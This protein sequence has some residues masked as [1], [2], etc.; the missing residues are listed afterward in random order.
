MIA[1]RVMQVSAHQV[2][3]VI[4]MRH[5]FVPAGWTMLV[6]A[7]RL[8]RALHGIGRID[9]DGVL[10]DMILVHVVQMPVVQII[11]V[12]L[13]AY[14]RMPAVGTMLVGMVGMMLLGAGGH[15][16][17]FL[18]LCGRSG[19]GGYRLSAACSMALSTKRTTWVSESE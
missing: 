16:V 1:M 9:R 7:T 13:M 18:L 10:V 4:S 3:D 2:I 8:R 19:T 11:D 5:G 12:A 14:R 6:R 17:F 15:G